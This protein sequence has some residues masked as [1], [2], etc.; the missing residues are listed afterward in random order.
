MLTDK[1]EGSP[2]ENVAWVSDVAA[3][4]LRR[5]GYRYIALN[6]GAS[7]RG[8]HNSL[9]NHLGNEDPAILLCQ[10]EDHAV[11]IAHGYAKATG[12]PMACVLHAN[13][14]LM[15]GMMLI[16]SAWCDRAPMLVLGATGPVD[17]AKRRPWID[18]IHT[19]SDQGGIIRDIVKWDNQP[20]SA[21][22]LVETMLRANFLTRTAPSAPVYVCLDAGLQE[23]SLDQPLQFPNIDRFKAPPAPRAQQQTIEEAATLLSQAK[24]PIILVGRGERSTKAWN[25]RIALAERL[26]ACVITEM[27]TGAVFPTDHPGHVVQPFRGSSSKAANAVLRQA[28]VILSLDWIDLS[29]ALRSLDHQYKLIHASLDHMLHNGAHMNY[30]ALSPVDVM[31]SAQADTVV[32]DLLERLGPGEQRAPWR[33][34][35]SRASKPNNSS[36]ITMTQVATELRAAFEDPDQVCFGALM[37]EWPTELWPFRDPFSYFGQDGGG[38][39]GAGPGISVGVALAMHQKGRLPV[40][41]IGDGDILMSSSALWTATRHRIPLLVLVNNNNSYLNDELHQETIARRRN[42]TV[43]NKGVGQRLEDPD[44]DIANLARSYGAV[45]IGPVKDPCDVRDAIR[46]GVAVL[47]QGGVAVIDFRIPPRAE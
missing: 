33:P 42:R 41:V 26:G 46:K 24:C 47:K 45:G 7:Y 30:L 21:G 3:Q 15:H 16:Y 32:A 28:D 27:K 12:E 8:L 40:S 23:A 44:V 4:M 10:H 5:L 43:G 38:A 9:V 22:A 35:V 36:R 20:T 2:D 25:A 39:L 13:I 34:A 29:G 37:R 18:W 17:A 19:S 14:G 6:P 1:I 11:A 31:M